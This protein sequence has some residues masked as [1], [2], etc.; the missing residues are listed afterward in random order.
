MYRGMAALGHP[1]CNIRAAWKNQAVQS[2]ILEW[3]GLDLGALSPR[4]VLG[5]SGLRG[6]PR[7]CGAENSTRRMRTAYVWVLTT[8]AGSTRAGEARP[9]PWTPANL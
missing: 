9:G 5:Y 6:T 8:P 3:G 7:P 2:G 4:L 1:H